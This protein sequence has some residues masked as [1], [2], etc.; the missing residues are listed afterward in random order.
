V[1]QSGRIRFANLDVQAG[2]SPTAVTEVTGRDMIGGA[3]LCSMQQSVQKRRD[4]GNC[5]KMLFAYIVTYT[6]MYI[7]IYISQL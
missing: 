5:H 7:Y 2:G 6:S 3:G 4:V 1:K